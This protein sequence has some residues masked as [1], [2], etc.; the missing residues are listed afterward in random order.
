MTGLTFHG[1]AFLKNVQLIEKVSTFYGNE[2]FLIVFT[3]PVPVPVFRR[4]ILAHILTRICLRPILMLSYH[5]SLGV[6]SGFFSSDFPTTIL[7][8]FLRLD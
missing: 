6:P 4:T 8:E 3:K 1:A 7:Y 2:L 5:L